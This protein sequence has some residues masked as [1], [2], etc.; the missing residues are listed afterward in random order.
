[1]KDDIK[2]DIK[3]ANELKEIL[4]SK[5]PLLKFKIYVIL[6]CQKCYKNSEVVNNESEK[7]KI[8]NICP[9]NKF[10]RINMQNI[11]ESTIKEIVKELN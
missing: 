3:D 9:Q 11:Y 1:V 10:Q 5:Y 6:L 7:I 8:I 4:I 2:D